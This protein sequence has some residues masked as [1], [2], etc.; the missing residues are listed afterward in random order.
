MKKIESNFINMLLVLSGITLF[1]AVTLASVYTLT[2][3]S[4]ANAQQTKKEEA[5]RAVLP[6]YDHVDLKPVVMNDG[7]ETTRV[8]KAYD[9]NNVLVGAAVQS[10]SNNG[11][12]GPV[13]VMVGFNN[14]GII[15]NYV[16]LDQHETPGLGNK[17]ENWFKTDKAKQDIRG[18]NAS[19][20][21]LTVSRDGG[22]VDAITAATISSRAFLFAV[23]NAY[24]AFTHSL[25][26][27]P[28][29]AKSKVDAPRPILND[30]TSTINKDGMKGPQP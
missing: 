9:K 8:Y 22:E 14:K 15:V 12:K 6:P 19:T 30:T 20:A 7:V 17:M 25:D 2:G 16:V 4:I 5:I 29:V 24:F 18:K 26:T 28:N 13:N 3:K 21:N 11:Y 10:T 27:Q 23:R 1:A